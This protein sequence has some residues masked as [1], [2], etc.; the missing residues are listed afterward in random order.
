MRNKIFNTCN[1]SVD[2]IGGA[3]G[4]ANIEHILGI[5]VLILTIF[6]VLANSVYKIYTHIKKREIEAILDDVDDTIEELK[7]VGKNEKSN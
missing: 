5:V 1:Y 6:N 4:L 2:A 3:Y 7:E